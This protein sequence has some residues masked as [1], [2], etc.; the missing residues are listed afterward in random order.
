MQIFQVSL[1]QI[2]YYLC[3]VQCFVLSPERKWFIKNTFCSSSPFNSCEYVSVALVYIIY[4][5]F[6][7]CVVKCLLIHLT[8]AI[9]NKSVI[10]TYKMFFLQHIWYF[11]HY[12][13]CFLHHIKCIFAT[14]TRTKLFCN[15][16]YSI[17]HHITLFFVSYTVRCYLQ[18]WRRFK[19]PIFDSLCIDIT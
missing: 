2:M 18:H 19:V 12:I 4:G 11:L 1:M 13:R 7:M 16:L 9:Y 15:I 5:A 10:A 14:Y 8:L 3:E 17:I 6:N